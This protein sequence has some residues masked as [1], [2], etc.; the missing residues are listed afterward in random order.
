M[1]INYSEVDFEILK[2]E[3]KIAKMGEN[4]YSVTI[5]IKITKN[6]REIRMGNLV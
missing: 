4:R 5:Y 6:L 2:K 1:L 3:V